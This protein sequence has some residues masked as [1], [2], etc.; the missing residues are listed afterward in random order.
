MIDRMEVFRRLR[1]ACI[2]AGSQAAFA[3]RVGVSQSMMCDVLAAR[4]SPSDAMLAA[5]GVERRRLVVYRDV[6]K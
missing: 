2:A 4:R 5:V 1:A 6:A 3:E